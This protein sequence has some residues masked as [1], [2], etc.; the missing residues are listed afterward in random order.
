MVGL[1]CTLVFCTLY[2]QMHN[3]DYML[4]TGSHFRMVKILLQ[5]INA[6]M[7]LQHFCLKIRVIKIVI[8]IVF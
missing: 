1:R 2:T 5:N 4:K 6:K 7:H 8:I 3:S